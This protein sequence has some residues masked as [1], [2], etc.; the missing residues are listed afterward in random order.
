MSAVQARLA[1]VEEVTGDP[2]WQGEVFTAYG[3]SMIR[4]V[5]GQ[6]FLEAVRQL[7][8]DQ[9]AGPFRTHHGMHF[10]RVAEHHEPELLPFDVVQSQVE[11]DYLMELIQTAVRDHVAARVP[12][13]D[14][15]IEP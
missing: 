8:A 15:R 14:I 1:A 7:P 13:Y 10:V 5:F 9:W 2:F 6:S 12:D 4:T 11:N 3:H